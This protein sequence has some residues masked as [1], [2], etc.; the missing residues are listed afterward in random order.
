MQDGPHVGRAMTRSWGSPHGLRGK[1]S[2]PTP[3]TW[4]RSSCR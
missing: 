3:R 4:C 2:L 1:G